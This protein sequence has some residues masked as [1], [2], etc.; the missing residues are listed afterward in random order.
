MCMYNSSQ[1]FTTLLQITNEAGTYNCT[2]KV[3]IN[4]LVESSRHRHSHC[5]IS[6]QAERASTCFKVPSH[7]K[8]VYRR[9]SCFCCSAQGVLIHAAQVLFLD[10]VD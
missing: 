8:T 1:T 7:S 5:Q 6:Q 10:E 3:Q 4:K 2:S 9:L